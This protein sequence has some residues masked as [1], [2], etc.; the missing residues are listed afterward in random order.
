MR[1]KV[2]GVWNLHNRLSK[3]ELDFFIMLSS[4]VGVS[5]N[6]SQAAYV[7]ASVFLDAFANYRNRQGLPAVTL[8]LGRIADIGFIAENEAARRGVRDLWSRDISGEEVMAMIKSAILTP[9]RQPGPGSSIT[10][11][12]SWS[13]AADPVYLT[14]IF[15]HFRRAAM[16][17][18]PKTNQAGGGGGATGRMREILRQ[19]ASVEEA[20][21]KTCEGIMAKMSALL[22]IPLEDISSAKSMS[23][24]GIDSLVAVE[25]RNWLLRELDST[26][27]ILELLANVSLLQLSMKIVKK[28]KL[29]DPALLL[30]DGEVVYRCPKDG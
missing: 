22:M 29:V 28:S 25:M 21:Q 6:P 5:G 19:A 11:L 18:V 4:V 20:A 30:E 10:G 8:D 15:A 27:P 9:L 12:K 7:A 24:Y 16:E 13:P 2:D 17:R 26:L 23:E 3:T 14:P 1:P